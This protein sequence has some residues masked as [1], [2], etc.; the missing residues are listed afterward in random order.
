MSDPGSWER[1]REL[2]KT[3]ADDLESE[4]NGRYGDHLLKYEHNRIKYARDM[5][6]VRDIREFL[7]K[8]SDAT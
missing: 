5:Q 1:A 6:I 3:A 4:I 8:P 7:T 2:L